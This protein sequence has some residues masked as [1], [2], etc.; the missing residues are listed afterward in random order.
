MLVIKKQNPIEIV[1]IDLYA[2]VYN[3]IKAFVSLSGVQT[4]IMI[5]Y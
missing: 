2:S 4:E 5:D 1:G 3:F